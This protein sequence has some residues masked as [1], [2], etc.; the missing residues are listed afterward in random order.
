MSRKILGID[1][2]GRDGNPTGFC[3]IFGGTVMCVGEFRTLKW[4]LEY[5]LMLRPDIVA[6]DAPLGLPKRGMFRDCDI[7]LK[8]HGISPLSPMLPS[9][10][11]L[12]NRALRLVG[13]LKENRIAYIETFP[14][15]ALRVLGYKRKPKSFTERRKYFME[16]IRMF[17]LRNLVDPYRLS[18]DEFDAFLCALAGYCF[19]R[20]TYMAF[21]GEECSVILPSAPSYQS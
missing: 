4:L 16:I 1:L 6:I 9:M 11:M 13:F 17:D 7:M 21:S 3:L 15:G 2:S 20:R 8:K 18:K 19:I 10:R 14:A 5:I 12:V